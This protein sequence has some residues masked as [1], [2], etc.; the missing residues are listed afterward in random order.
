[1]VLGGPPATARRAAGRVR[2]SDGGDRADGRSGL[3]DLDG[4]G[5]PGAGVTAVFCADRE[6]TEA[7]IRGV[8][9]AGRLAVVRFGDFGLADL[10]SPPVTV[11]SS[12][13]C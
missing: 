11:V 3:A 9:R 13:P 6:Q 5:L 12:T 10:V 7:V 2:P 1:M 4:A 8:G